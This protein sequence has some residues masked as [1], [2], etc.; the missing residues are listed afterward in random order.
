MTDQLAFNLLLDRKIVPIH[1]RRHPVR[2]YVLGAL[3]LGYVWGG[4]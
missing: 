3:R 2:V 4:A 1:V